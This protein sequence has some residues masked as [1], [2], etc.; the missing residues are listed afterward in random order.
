MVAVTISGIV[1]SD[2]EGETAAYVD[3]INNINERLKKE[4]SVCINMADGKAVYEKGEEN[5]I[6]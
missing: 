6:F 1:S 3:S 2:Y 5:D 4:A